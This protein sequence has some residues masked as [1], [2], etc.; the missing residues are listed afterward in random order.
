MI[1]GSIVALVT[2]FT[3]SGDV[4]FDGLKRL[5]DFQITAGTNAI[6]AV[7]TTGE[8]ASLTHREDSEVIRAVVEYA[9]GR[10]PIIAGAGSNSTA[11]ACKLTIAAEKAGADAILSVAPYY[12]KPPQRGLIAHFKAVAENTELPIILYNVPGRTVTD[13]SDDTTLTLAEI[14]NITGIKDATGDMARAQYL[15][16]HRPEGFA[17][18]SGDDPT[19][20]ELCLMGGD[21]DISVTANVA[22]GLMSNM[23]AAA[24]EG[25]R[26]LSNELN[27]KLVSL[28]QHLFIESNPIPTKWVLAK[29]GL[30]RSDCRLPLVPLAKN[31]IKPVTEACAKAGIEL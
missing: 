26:D 30:I 20:L 29:M 25:D 10:V 27:D 17:V 21:G 31:F 2:P 5:V 12:N 3:D 23:V 4:D 28:H 22:P 7:G 19:A 18:Y 11:E 15:I 16:K 13:L 9:N 6:V 8:S 14:Q 1:R 24:L